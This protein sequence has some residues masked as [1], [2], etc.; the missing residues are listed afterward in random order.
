MS[1]PVPIAWLEKREDN[2]L[3]R[4]NGNEIVLDN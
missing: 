4:L 1:F 2:K 3:D